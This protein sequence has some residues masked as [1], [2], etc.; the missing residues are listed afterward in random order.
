MTF[1]CFFVKR[2]CRKLD[3]WKYIVGPHLGKVEPN[4]SLLG[5]MDSVYLVCCLTE[6]QD[7]GTS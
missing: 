2:L 7:K 5:S 4:L 6:R 3:F 1:A